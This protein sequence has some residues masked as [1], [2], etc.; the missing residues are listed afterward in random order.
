VSTLNAWRRF[1]ALTVTEQA[2]VLQAAVWLSA[3]WCGLRVSGFRRW[4]NFLAG[5]TPDAPQSAAPD[6]DLLPHALQTA[7]LHAAAARHLF[8]HT[9]CLERALVLAFLLRRRGIAAELRFGARKEAAGLE[10]HAWVEYRGVP[11]DEDLGE[12]RHFLPF[13]GLKPLLETL[14]D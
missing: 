9:N 7:R 6:R 1:A 5:F 13:E 2:V 4:Q 8:F 12:H 14:P 11:L 3:T 10:A